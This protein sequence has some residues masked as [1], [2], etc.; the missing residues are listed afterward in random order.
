MFFDFTYEILN[1]S[2]RIFKI[3]YTTPT[4]GCEDIVKYIPIF[5]D[6]TEAE[7]RDIIL[8]H[9]PHEIWRKQQTEILPG[10]FDEPMED[11]IYNISSESF[12][13]NDVELREKQKKDKALN[14]STPNI[15][16]KSSAKI[17]FPNVIPKNL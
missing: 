9:A 12:T 13:A 10:L 17:E 4:Q 16:M 8:D 5:I 3:R 2:N 6:E 11:V 1:N 14:I 15:P 7:V